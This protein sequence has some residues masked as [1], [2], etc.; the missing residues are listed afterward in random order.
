MALNY[1][2]KLVVHMEKIKKD[3]YRFVRNIII[4]DVKL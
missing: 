1:D 4:G 3:D 2:F